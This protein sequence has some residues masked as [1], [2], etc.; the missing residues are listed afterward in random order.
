MRHFRDRYD[1]S[2]QA[3]RQVLKIKP[4]AMQGA[5]NNPAINWGAKYSSL[6]FS[7]PG[8]LTQFYEIF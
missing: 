2:K 4:L 5:N 8:C 3:E 6:K 1:T 7:A